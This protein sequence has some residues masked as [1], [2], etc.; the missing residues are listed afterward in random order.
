M[1]TKTQICI[2][3]A[4]TIALSQNGPSIFLKSSTANICILCHCIKISP[5]RKTD[6]KCP[7]CLSHLA[8]IYYLAVGS[9]ACKS[10]LLDQ[11]PALRLIFTVLFY[12]RRVRGHARI[13]SCLV[14]ICV[15]MVMLVRSGCS[16]VTLGVKQYLW[17]GGLGA[18]GYKRVGPY[19]FI[20][21]YSFSS[22]FLPWNKVSRKI[23]FF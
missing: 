9:E 4:K 5:E 19:K 18:V 15:Y 14:L 20:R 1:Y 8:V 10:A 7:P 6:Q 13:P 3:I 11:W 16:W 22:F 2:K 21:S 17:I 23:V 12:C